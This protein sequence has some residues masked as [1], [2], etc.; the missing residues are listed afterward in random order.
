MFNQTWK[1]VDLQNE[2]KKLK[3]SY[4]GRKSDLV[5]RLNDFKLINHDEVQSDN[6]SETG[7]MTDELIDIDVNNLTNDDMEPGVDNEDN[8]DEDDIELENKN[9]KRVRFMYTR[10]EDF[11]SLDLAMKKLEDYSIWK[12]HRNRTTKD[13]LKKCFV[14]SG[15][16]FCQKSAYILLHADDETTSIWFSSVD[17]DHSSMKNFFGINEV[18]KK[19]IEILYKSSV[20]TATRIRLALRERV[21]PLMPKKFETDQDVINELYVT[22]VEIPTNLQ[23]NN[24]LN[25]TLR[26]KLQNRNGKNKFSYGDLVSWVEVN[27]IVP[28]NEHE[29]FVIDSFIH[30]NEKY[31]S[32]S[33]IR[34]SFSTRILL[35]IAMKT[36]HV[37]ADATYKLIWHN[38]PVFLIGKLIN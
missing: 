32:A 23:I 24:Y 17:H 26:P 14:C 22:G 36:K 21:E 35:K 7:N 33:I 37:C 12:F 27:S 11:P 18:T 20:N 13:G 3:I 9:G 31:P 8:D 16:K 28:D 5:K 6:S 34:I 10:D 30:Y 38:F 19:Q 29:P 25:N 2:C 15:G 1:V 4:A